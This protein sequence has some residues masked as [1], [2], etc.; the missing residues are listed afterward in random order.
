MIDS[1]LNG[2]GWRARWRRSLLFFYLW[3]WRRRGIAF[4]YAFAFVVLFVF[5]YLAIPPCICGRFIFCS[6]FFNKLT[7][8]AEPA[9]CP[10]PVFELPEPHYGR[11]QLTPFRRGHTQHASQAR[12]VVGQAA[13]LDPPCYHQELE[14]GAMLLQAEVASVRQIGV[15]EQGYG[16]LSLLHRIILTTMRPPFTGASLE[17]QKPKRWS[18]TSSASAMPS[19]PALIEASMLSRSRRRMSGG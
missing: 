14:I 11:F 18:F 15:T 4:G 3:R 8:F 7:L 1:E 9:L 17:S 5:R 12:V 10:L 19:T 13:S 6:F 2:L 16:R